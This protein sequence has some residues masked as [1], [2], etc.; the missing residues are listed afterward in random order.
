MATDAT[1]PRP[2]LYT[3]VDTHNYPG[4]PITL[5]AALSGIHR[6]RNSPE[7][8]DTVYVYPCTDRAGTALHVVYVHFVPNH[9]SGSAD[10]IDVYEIPTDALTE[11]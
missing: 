10:V 3:K 8:V 2:R 5:I 4:E 11:L 7:A 9:W 6:A 1:A